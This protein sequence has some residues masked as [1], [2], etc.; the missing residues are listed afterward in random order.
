[1]TAI[2]LRVAVLLLAAYAFYLSVMLGACLVRGYRW[3]KQCSASA[4]LVPGIR[5]ALVD[6]LAGNNDLSQLR[7]LVEAG[8]RDVAD[9]ILGFQ[10]RIGGEARDRLCELAIEFALVHDWCLD[11]R[12][13]DVVR[14]RT[15]VNHLSFVCANEPC[16]R[17]TGDLL[18]ALLEDEDREVRLWAARALLESGGPA[19][20]EEVFEFAVS[21]NPLIRIL[22]TEELRRHAAAL[23]ERAV[24][25]ILRSGDPARILVT[26]EILVAWERALPVNDLHPLLEHTDRGIRREALRLAPL[27]PATAENKSAVI[28]ALR[29]EDPDIFTVAALSAGR[30]NLQESLPILAR[31]L[32]VG[33]AELARSAAAALAAMPPRGWQVL[34]ELS[35]NPSAVTAG[36]AAEALDR[37]RREAGA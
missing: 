22:L 10:G 37:A 27:V 1:M 24:P 12:S 3:R 29:D 13:K 7:G 23:C 31:C 30:L 16:R 26:L 19:D 17:V 28:C 18:L 32:R 33:G 21:Q 11:A 35:A 25:A 5:D 9:V 15:A 6:Y 14:R 2:E 4:A 36:A 20:V 8:R 34:E